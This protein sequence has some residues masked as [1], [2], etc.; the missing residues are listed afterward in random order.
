MNTSETARALSLSRPILTLSCAHCG[1]AFKARN[2]YALYCSPRCQ[3]AARRA[4]IKAEQANTAEE[5]QA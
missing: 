4:Q 2:D 5:P 3:K 1:A